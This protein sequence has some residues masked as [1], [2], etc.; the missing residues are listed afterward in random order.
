[1]KKSLALCDD[2]LPMFAL[3]EETADN[4]IVPT[5]IYSCTSNSNL[6]V[7]TVAHEAC[8]SDKGVDDATSTFA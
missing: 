2:L 6:Q 8:G 3:K 1:M 5:L 7:L 4:E